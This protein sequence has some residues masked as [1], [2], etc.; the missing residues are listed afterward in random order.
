MQRWYLGLDSSTQSLTA[1]GIA[2]E[3]RKI[4]CEI[5]LNFDRELPAYGTR[6]G[7]LRH[8][9]PTVVHAPPL[10]WVEALDKMFE[11]LRREGLPLGELAAV[12]VSGQQH[13]SVYLNET[14]ADRLARLDP[15]VPLVENLRGVFSRPTSPIWMDS[16]TSVECAEITEALGGSAEVARRTGSAAFERFTGPQIRKFYK[17]DPEGYL[18]TAHIALVS[19]FLPSVLAGRIA[20]IDVGDGAGMNLMN[21]QARDWD[22]AALAATAP[23]LRR[24]LPPIV[25]SWTVVGPVARYFAERYGVSP[26][27]QVVVGSGDNPCSLVGLGLVRSGMVAI[28]LGTSDTY[29]GAMDECRVSLE[30]EGHV[31]GSPT[32]G[33]MTLVCFKNGSL[34]RE[35]VRDQLGLDWE[36]F[37]RA[38][39]STPPALGGRG[40]MLPWFEPEITPKVLK[41]GAR[42]QGVRPDDPAVCRA[43]VEAQMMAMRIHTRWMGVR[44]SC[45]YATGGASANPAIL[46]VMADVHRCPVYRFETTASAALGAALRAFHAWQR[47]A[48]DPLSW[49]EVVRGFA[50]P[51]RDS[52]VDPSPETAAVYDAME[53]AYRE[54]EQTELARSQT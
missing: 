21:I 47:S 45:I 31:F 50:E 1:V 48:G 5:S 25:E 4:L 24:R 18:R 49:D 17:M 46:R 32:G 42:Y 37:A 43:A 19:S 30:G 22:P 34:A 28:S 13:G 23:D 44:P 54:F 7:T 38:V 3:G 12:S 36:G 16:S 53:V 35:R 27:A 20:P 40:L 14:A 33:Y 52:R 39:F 2:P 41:P 26:Q 6:N 11:R 51:V 29:F 15:S 10:M 9:D 8:E